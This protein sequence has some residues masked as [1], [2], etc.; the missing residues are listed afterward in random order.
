MDLLDH[1]AG[2]IAFLARLSLLVDLLAVALKALG[3]RWINLS[4]QERRWFSGGNTRISG[5]QTF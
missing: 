3:V 5:G 4:G 2:T 1:F